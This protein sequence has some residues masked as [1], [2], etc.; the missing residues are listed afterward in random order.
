MSRTPVGEEARRQLRS[1]A[2]TIGSGGTGTTAPQPHSAAA[3]RS[4]VEAL[5]P[6]ER[7]EFFLLEL[8]ALL[9]LLPAAKLASLPTRLASILAT[10]ID[11]H[12]RG[13]TSAESIGLDAENWPLRVGLLNY[14]GAARGSEADDDARSEAPSVGSQDDGGAANDFDADR[15]WPGGPIRPRDDEFGEAVWAQYAHRGGDAADDGAAAGDDGGG[16]GGGV[17]DTRLAGGRHEDSIGLAAHG[18]DMY[19]DYCDL[20]GGAPDACMARDMLQQSRFSRELKKQRGRKRKL[21][22]TRRD[23]PIAVVGMHKEARYALYRAVIAWQWANPLGAE[24][25][26]RLPLCVERG[27][28]RLFP[29]PTCG[30]ACDYGDA[31]VR[32]GH[33]TGFRSAA[34]SRAIREGAYLDVGDAAD[35]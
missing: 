16:G 34:E 1:S 18:R 8:E 7:M 13:A 23:T 35:E 25:R 6:E 27:V 12:N 14:G 30:E 4:V 33:Y 17:R 32:A 21:E 31:C 19:C 20:G 26:V 2:S 28:R 9:P 24:K 29:H 15:L 3:A 22:A 5:P 11:E 10:R